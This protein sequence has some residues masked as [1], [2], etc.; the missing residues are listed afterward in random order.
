[1]MDYEWLMPITATSV[2]SRLFKDSGP[3]SLPIS[4]TMLLCSLF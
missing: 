2:L 1:M 4:D 3:E